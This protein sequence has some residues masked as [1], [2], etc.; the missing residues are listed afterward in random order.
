MTNQFRQKECP[1][2]NLR[3]CKALKLE[4]VS[5]RIMPTYTIIWPCDEMR[6]EGIYDTWPVH[7][8]KFHRCR[9]WVDLLVQECIKR[10][11]SHTLFNELLSYSDFIFDANVEDLS[12]V[13]LKVLEDNQ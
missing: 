4:L 2:F 8:M 12:R 13:A 11:L 7:K 5:D 10:N 9:D 6:P 1:E 3:C